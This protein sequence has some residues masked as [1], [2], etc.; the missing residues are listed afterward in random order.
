M[1]TTT[2]VITCDIC[3]TVWEQVTNWTHELATLSSVFNAG[4]APANFGPVKNF[5]PDFC[6][7]CDAAA[8]VAIQTVLA[9][10]HD[11]NRE[12]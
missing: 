11:I 5:R 1:R 6:D 7:D 10:R 9:N 4:P 8:T 3:G 2:A 12:D